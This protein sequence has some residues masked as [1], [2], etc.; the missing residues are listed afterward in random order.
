MI[1]GILNLSLTGYLIATLI[2]TQITIAA[3][4]LYLHRNQAHRSVDLHPAVSHFFRFWLWLT[5]GMVTRE[6][7]S[8]HRKHHAHSDR[9]GDPHS[10]A[11]FGIRKV[12]WEGAELYRGE[13]TNADTIA[14]YSHG[15][16]NDWIENKLYLPHSAKGLILML[17][18][19]L[20]LFGLAGITIWAIQLLW[21]P[22][23]AAGVINGLGHYWGYR[24]FESRDQST[25]VS[26]WGLWIGGEELHNNH[27]AYPS[28]ARFSSRWWEFDIGWFY[29]RVLSL[30]GLAKVRKTAPRPI[31]L[32][33]KTRIDMDTLRAVI[34]A[35]LD[36]TASYARQVVAPVLRQEL[37]WADRSWGRALRQC[38][39]L[40]LK[41]QEAV[42]SSAKERLSAVLERYHR[43][44]TVYQFRQQL[45]EVWDRTSN[46]Q[47]QLL[48]ALQDWCQ[49]AEATGIQALEDFARSL[50]GFELR[51]AV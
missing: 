1:D 24:N 35:R 14:K 39:R 11:V 7:V 22:I 33:G 10:P 44:R 30:L 50:R 6:W 13:A 40:L 16:P 46:S 26:P 47:E 43:L 17:L 25:N 41:G 34:V 31:F 32:P 38:K 36:V 19:D 51:P 15:T 5:T 20:L 3:V 2:V 4:T 45:Q 49:R 9:N 18:I 23:W 37:A 8:I 12:L 28:S 21:I 48:R 42:D 29:I 27:H